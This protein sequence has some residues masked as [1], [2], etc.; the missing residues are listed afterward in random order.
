MGAV[1]LLSL[2]TAGWAGSAV[3]AQQTV[4][5][6]DEAAAPKDCDSCTARHQRLGKDEATRDQERATLKDLYET[7]KEVPETQ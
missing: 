5:Q 2:S 1:A 6:V 7:S 4:P 3:P